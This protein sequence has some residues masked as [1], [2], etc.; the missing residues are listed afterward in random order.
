M[1]F[2]PFPTPDNLNSCQFKP[3]VNVLHQPGGLRSVLARSWIL[4][5]VEGYGAVF[6]ILTDL[7]W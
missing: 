6:P 5:E 7:G 2:S 4:P 3:R 1:I